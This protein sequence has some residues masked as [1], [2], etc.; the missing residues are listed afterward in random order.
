MCSFVYG[1]SKTKTKQVAG[2]KADNEGSQVQDSDKLATPPSAMTPQNYI[3]S[4]TGVW[5]GS[6]P[7]EMRNPHTGIDLTRG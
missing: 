5:P 4:A 3:P 2:A 7:A 1:G 6:R